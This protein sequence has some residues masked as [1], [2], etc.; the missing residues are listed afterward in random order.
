MNRYL[1]IQLSPTDV[2]AVT[3]LNASPFESLVLHKTDL[4]NCKRMHPRWR[5][6]LPNNTDALFT[7]LFA[8][9][10]INRFYC[11]CVVSLEFF[12]GNITF[13]NRLDTYRYLCQDL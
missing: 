9:V 13:A 2:K 8:D 11:N 1:C 12:I 7:F 10:T 3:L 5:D 6:K 4:I